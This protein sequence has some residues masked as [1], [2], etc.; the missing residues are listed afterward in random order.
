MATKSSRIEEITDEEPAPVSAHADTASAAKAEAAPEKVWEAD[1]AKLWDK[2]KR[3]EPGPNDPKLPPQLSEYST[4]TTDQ[5]FENMNRVPFFMRE[6]DD[7]DGDGGSNDTL[8]ALKALAYE[9][10]PDE[11]AT[12]FK[13]QGNEAYKEKRY[14][15]AIQFYGKALEMKCGV[16]A[17]DVACYNNK[18]ACNLE[19][20]NY[21]R[22]IND[23]K[24]AMI[25][26]PKNQK[27]IYRS[28]TA[29]L[30]VGRAQ[31]A[32]DLCEYAKT[33]DVYNDSI[34]NVETQAKKKLADNVAREKRA[35]AKKE[36]EEST[37]K[38]LELAIKVRKIKQIVTAN[39]PALPEGVHIHLEEPLDPTSSLLV[40]ILLLYPCDMQSDFLAEVD[41]ASTPNQALSTVFESPPPWFTNDHVKLYDLKNLEVFVQTEAGGLVKIG[42][43]VS[44]E[45]VFSAPSPSV[46]LIDNVI[47]LHVVP[48]DKREE[49]VKTWSKDKA[50]KMMK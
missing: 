38:N 4:E 14:A 29:F 42:K 31:E 8:E 22:C 47:T 45:S 37:E 10:E 20:R 13:N 44:F 26:D 43:K 32:L 17:I 18:A 3:Y 21:R 33:C 12:N 15:D 30:M 23:C 34:K 25:L 36:L 5:F 1:K 7:T 11:V 46:P 9:G 35:L 49:W 28:C 6:L 50:L 48:K 16:V 27:A 40:P 39:P 19:L 24:A 2:P 41:I